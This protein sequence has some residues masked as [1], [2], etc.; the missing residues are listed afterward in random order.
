MKP[1]RYEIAFDLIRSRRDELA[2]SDRPEGRVVFASRLVPPVFIR[3]L[4][5]DCEYAEQSHPAEG[6]RK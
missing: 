6:R 2:V 3:P 4:A 5:P 1:E